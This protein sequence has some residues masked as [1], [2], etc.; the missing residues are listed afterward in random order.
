M[1]YSVSHIITYPSKELC[2]KVA[3]EEVYKTKCTEF[4]RLKNLKYSSKQTNGHTY[5][6]LK[7]LF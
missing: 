7:K 2:S 3:L 6:Y 4:D 5:G 1:L